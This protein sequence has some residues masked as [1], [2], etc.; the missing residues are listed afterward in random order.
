MVVHPHNSE[1][2]ASSSSLST[3]GNG[4]RL[5]GA[6][7]VDEPVLGISELAR[8][9][10][11]SKSAVQRLVTTFAAHGFLARTEDGRYRLGIRLFEVASQVPASLEL[12]EVAL[13]HLR[14][15]GHRAQETVH[16]AVRDGTEMVYIE[17]M[18]ANRTIRMYSRIGRR[19]PMYCTGVGKAVLAFEPEDV[20]RQ[21]IRAGLNRFTHHTIADPATLAAELEGIRAA[22]YA[23]DREEIEIGLRCVAAPIRDHTAGVVAGISISGPSQRMDARR[24]QELIPSVVETAAAISR[25]L[26]YWASPRSRSEFDVSALEK[27]SVLRHDEPVLEPT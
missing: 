13:P 7:S 15:L 14:D 23:L 3:L 8:R 26:G 1:S 6:F 4:I 18:E 22:G 9:L 5:L 25:N 10:R 21:V 27:T 20:V 16:L 19:G 11:L 2:D 17:K 12:R 24:V